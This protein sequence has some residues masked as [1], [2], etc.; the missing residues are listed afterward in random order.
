M[1]K[2][3]SRKFLVALAVVIIATVALFV[4]RITGAEWLA[5]TNVA[6]GLYIGGNVVQ[7]GVAKNDPPS[8]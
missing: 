2:Y 8:G 5:A 4:G 1:Q 3:L 7:K 6:I